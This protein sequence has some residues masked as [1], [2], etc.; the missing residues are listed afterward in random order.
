MEYNT[1]LN[2]LFATRPFNAANDDDAFKQQLL[3]S[4]QV[5][6][7]H[8][9]DVN[10]NNAFDQ[11]AVDVAAKRRR[12]DAVRLL[13][14]AGGKFDPETL[15]EEMKKEV[16]Q[17]EERELATGD[18][19]EVVDHGEGWAGVDEDWDEDGVGGGDGGGDE[20]GREGDEGEGRGEGGRRE[21]DEEEG[22]PIERKEGEGFAADESDRRNGKEAALVWCQNFVFRL[23]LA[24]T[25]LA[26][27]QI[28][29][30]LGTNLKEI[31]AASTAYF[32]SPLSSN[33]ASP[34]SPSVSSSSASPPPSATKAA[35]EVARTSTNEQAI[36]FASEGQMAH[37]TST[38][39]RAIDRVRAA[40]RLRL[41]KRRA[42]AE[43]LR[44]PSALF[45][46]VLLY[47]EL[48]DVIL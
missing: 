13:I 48:D 32:S 4:A 44:L 33:A 16:E 1:A 7:K 6:L 30:S 36:D 43:Q 14:L 5:L 2:S 34:I 45:Q 9:V 35:G 38:N 15:K 27:I 39:E 19:I 29:R 3:V 41:E 11:S 23:P 22:R 46:F 47:D 12:F 10:V 42:K 25:H 28:R 24:L 17:E 26:R 31:V 18:G 37:E 21:R 40:E 8:G 20:G